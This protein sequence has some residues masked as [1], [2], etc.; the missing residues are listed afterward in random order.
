MGDIVSF[1]ASN[2]G[3]VQNPPVSSRVSPGQSRIWH[4]LAIELYAN[5]YAA[6]HFSQMTQHER[7][8]LLVKVLP[9]GT[10]EFYTAILLDKKNLLGR[11]SFLDF[12][13]YGDAG[14]TDE[15]LEA[16]E[17]VIYG[18][19][20]VWARTVIKNLMNIQVEQSKLPYD[21]RN[22]LLRNA[23]KREFSPPTIDQK[24]TL[25]EAGFID[26]KN[27][28]VSD[29]VREYLS[30]ASEIIRIIITALY[31]MNGPRTMQG[32]NRLSY[33]ATARIT[34]Y[35]SR[36]VSVIH[37]KFLRRSRR[38]YFNE[39]LEGAASKINPALVQ[40]GEELFLCDVFELN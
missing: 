28:N 37:K 26:E 18:N 20:K 21:L 5:G 33:A 40:S 23:L 29:T 27:K 3:S 39:R 15:Q 38:R 4:A 32:R 7:N 22:E 14:F 1:R 19:C 9:A 34:G 10:R 36:R 8:K 25:M 2:N 13:P 24:P 31:E 30:P 12:K 6:I 16:H 11:K 17:T 35:S